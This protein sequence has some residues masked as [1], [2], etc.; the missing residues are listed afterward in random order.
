MGEAVAQNP[1][2]LGLILPLYPQLP[3]KK[4]K[5]CW[6]VVFGVFFGFFWFYPVGV[7]FLVT[8]LPH[9]PFP[10]LFS[11]GPISSFYLFLFYFLGFSLLP[12][13][14]CTPANPQ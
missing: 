9:G 14:F 1:T 3:C 2:A 10:G 11:A 8:L 7:V 5:F 4:I 13:I 12:F 6:F